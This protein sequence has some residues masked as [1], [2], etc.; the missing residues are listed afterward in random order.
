[1]GSPVLNWQSH[2]LIEKWYRLI[3]NKGRL[4]N[5]LA[6]SS[7]SIVFHL[8][9]IN[10]KQMGNILLLFFFYILLN[11]HFFFRLI[12]TIY[13]KA[14]KILC[15]NTLKKNIN[16]QCVLEITVNN[17]CLDCR[18]AIYLFVSLN[19]ILKYEIDGGNLI[20]DSMKEIIIILYF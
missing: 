8:F 1:M 19:C 4:C 2:E 18:K 11:S 9:T 12:S 6:K 16:C 13:L 3:K 10:L 7:F 20:C 17:S 5:L 15:I 14:V